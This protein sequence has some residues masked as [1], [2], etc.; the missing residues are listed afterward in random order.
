MVE[1]HKKQQEITKSGQ[2]KF[3]IQTRRCQH[4]E[5]YRSLPDS[6]A[7]T[8]AAKK[9]LGGGEDKKEADRE[10]T[11]PIAANRLRQSVP[12]A[13]IRQPSHDVA[14]RRGRVT[15]V[16]LDTWRDDKGSVTG[17]RPSV[18]QALRQLYTELHS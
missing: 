9:K 10:R 13:H 6:H 15:R 5:A 8:D 7:K 14:T 4:H 1:M 17:R 3:I 2:E 12:T 18:R 16:R 11:D